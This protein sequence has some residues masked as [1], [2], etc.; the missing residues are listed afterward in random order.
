M[1]HVARTPCCP[2]WYQ[3]STP[4]NP[5]ATSP[6]SRPAPT[7]RHPA[8]RPTAPP[9]PRASP[10]SP[11]CAPR[12]PRAATSCPP[13]AS[14]SGATERVTLRR[15]SRS[16]ST[17]ASTWPWRAALLGSS[18]TWS[19]SCLMT[20]AT[21]HPLALTPRRACARTVWRGPT[22]PSRSASRCEGQGGPGRVGSWGRGGSGPGRGLTSWGRRLPLHPVGC[23]LLAQAPARFLSRAASNHSPAPLRLPPLP[24]PP[25]PG[26]ARGVGR[27]RGD[28]RTGAGPRG[29]HKDA[30][31]RRHDAVEPPQEG[32]AQRAEHAHAGVQHAGHGRLHVAHPHVGA[33]KLASDCNLPPRATW[34]GTRALPT[35]SPLCHHPRRPL[36]NCDEGTLVLPS[37]TLHPFSALAAATKSIPPD[38]EITPLSLF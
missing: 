22:P 18:S 19:T 7:A 21:S 2:H 37:P 10:P 5:R 9:T 17:P 32:H 6:Q 36:L 1:L 38:T 35:R 8:A 25:S 29:L 11:R 3:Q 15:R 4:P 13:P 31:R 20:P 26:A 12:C 33:L 16:P 24:T 14:T 28:A 30:G 27:Q 23:C 34:P